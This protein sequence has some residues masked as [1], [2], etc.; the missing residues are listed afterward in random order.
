MFLTAKIWLL[1][2]LFLYSSQN[3]LEL[4][5]QNDYSEKFRYLVKINFVKINLCCGDTYAKY[6]EEHVEGI[7]F[8]LNLLAYSEIIGFSQPG[9]ICTVSRSE[10][11]KDSWSIVIRNRKILWKHGPYCWYFRL[12]LKYL[13]W[14]YRTYIKTAKNCDFREELLIENDFETVLATCCCYGLGAMAS[15][16]VQKIATDQKG[17]RKCS[18]CVIICWITKIYLSITNWKKV[19]S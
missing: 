16:E 19:G 9:Y 5:A 8:L 13:G 2:W 14:P 11:C 12:N 17:Y 15:E 10:E 4:V 1:K 7:P 3:W 6:L 18:L